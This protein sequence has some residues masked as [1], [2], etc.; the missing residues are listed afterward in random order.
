MPPLNLQT[1]AHQETVSCCGEDSTYMQPSSP[2]PDL[3]GALQPLLP[4]T[5]EHML[6]VQPAQPSDPPD[7]SETSLWGHIVASV[8]LYPLHSIPLPLQGNWGCYSHI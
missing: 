7:P 2:R 5:A 1:K 8:D 3:C 6:T 4:A